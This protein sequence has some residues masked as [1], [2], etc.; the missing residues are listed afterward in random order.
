MYLS[1]ETILHANVERWRRN[2]MHYDP[3]HPDMGSFTDYEIMKQINMQ[4]PVMTVNSQPSEEVS[5]GKA[6]SGMVSYICIVT[7][8]EHIAGTLMACADRDNVRFSAFDFQTSF[9]ATSDSDTTGGSPLIINK[10]TKDYL[11]KCTADWSINHPWSPLDIPDINEYLIGFITDMISVS[12]P[13]N[14][15]NG[16]YLVPTSENLRHK[17]LCNVSNK[18]YISKNLY[19]IMFDMRTPNRG[20]AG[21]WLFNALREIESGITGIDERQQRRQLAK[22]K[23]ARNYKIKKPN[24]NSSNSN[25]NNNR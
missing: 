18:I 3:G 8:N 16:I 24:G 11:G 23:H 6:Y 22:F 20:H 10:N 25:S 14:K 17:D 12:C 13:R 1:F 5:K 9:F 4:F 7:N 15:A 2:E 19:Y 21:H